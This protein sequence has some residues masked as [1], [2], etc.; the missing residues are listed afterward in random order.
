MVS[1]LR[2]PKVKLAARVVGPRK[3]GGVRMKDEGHTWTRIDWR[4]N[5]GTLGSESIVPEKEQVRDLCIRNRRGAAVFA[6]GRK[7][8]ACLE[9]FNLIVGFNGWSV[10]CSR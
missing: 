2:I 3:V 4:H 5:I 10:P 7:E 6:R 8:T 9:G 1:S